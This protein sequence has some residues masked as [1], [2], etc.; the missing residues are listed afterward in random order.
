MDLFVRQVSYAHET[1]QHYYPMWRVDF[2]IDCKR[3]WQN[4][5][6]QTAICAEQVLY[7]ELGLPYRPR[8]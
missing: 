8:N 2:E 1:G 6:A 7:R 4:F 5:Q 3:R